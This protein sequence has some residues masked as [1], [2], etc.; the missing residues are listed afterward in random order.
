MRTSSVNR[1]TRETKIELSLNIDGNGVSNINTGVGFLDHMLTLF[2]AHS[3][4]DLN[5]QCDGD[6]YVDDHHS[7][8]DIG[9]CLGKAIKD[10][11]GSCAGIKR[12]GSTLLPMDE[13]LVMTVADV[14][15]RSYLVFDCDFPT[16]KIGSFDTELVKEFFQALVRS[17]SITL[18]IKK[19]Y[20]DNSHHIAEACFKSFA[21]SLKCACEID[22]SLNGKIPSTKGSL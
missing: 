8:E 4:I 17:A 10:A 1:N 3:M 12:Y 9:I 2:S 19:L 16:E 13:S 14:S 7:A 11:L 20:G 18:H 21:R 22:P 15:G 6:V 5:V